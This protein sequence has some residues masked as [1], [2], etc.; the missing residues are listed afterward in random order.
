[1]QFQFNFME[2]EGKKPAKAPTKSYKNTLYVFDI[3]SLKALRVR[4]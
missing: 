4:G 2:F 1:L 3:E